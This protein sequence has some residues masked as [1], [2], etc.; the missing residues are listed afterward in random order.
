M[1]GADD[2]PR[3]RR[4]GGS[5]VDVGPAA[6][7]ARAG[8]RQDEALVALVDGGVDRDEARCE[9]AC[10]PVT[11][12]RDRPV[13]GDDVALRRPQVR[14]GAR[15]REGLPA[16]LVGDVADR[17]HDRAAEDDLVHA[18]LGRNFVQECD[19]AFR[20]QRRSEV[21][22]EYAVD[23]LDVVGERGPCV[24]R[25]RDGY[26]VGRGA[27][28]ADPGE[29]GSVAGVAPAKQDLPEVKARHSHIRWGETDK[30]L[31]VF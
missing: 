15:A 5:G 13:V 18:V 29:H 27:A 4:G 24:S 20:Y 8:P 6:A 14:R 28:G 9:E 17:A 10:S 26:R 19:M 25:R 1:R 16:L 22:A 21:I 23:P 12:G 3:L 7:D 2:K 11:D 31:G 30:S